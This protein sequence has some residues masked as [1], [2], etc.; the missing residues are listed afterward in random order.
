MPR[1]AL[2]EAGRRPAP[3]HLCAVPAPGEGLVWL[4]DAGAAAWFEVLAVEPGAPPLVHVEH[5]P[6]WG[7]TEG[8]P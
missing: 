8:D 7:S 4:D 5:R 3:V 6:E 1:V 2:V